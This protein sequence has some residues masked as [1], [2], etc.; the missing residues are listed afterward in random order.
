MKF[1]DQLN[2]TYI[3]LN[4]NR[5]KG[6]RL[7]IDQQ[8]S[9]HTLNKVFFNF[10]IIIQS[11]M[12]YFADFIFHYTS[13]DL[14]VHL[15]Q[16]SDMTLDNEF[17]EDYN[18]I[19]NLVKILTLIRTLRSEQ[20]LN[21]K[22]PIKELIICCTNEFQLSNLIEIL[23]IEGNIMN[24]SFDDIHK[25][26]STEMLPNNKTIGKQF[27]K[28]SKQIL[29]SLNSLN[30]IQYN[31]PID[32][33]GFILN[34]EHFILNK[35]CSKKE[36]YEY[37]LDDILLYIDITQDDETNVLYHSKIIVRET[38]KF[39]QELGLKPINPIYINYNT[40]NDYFKSVIHNRK[41][42]IDDII[43]YDFS[44]NEEESKNELLGR[45]NISIEDDF[46]EIEIFEM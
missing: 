17:N 36:G 41:E 34:E 37:I 11:S 30:D 7:L 38:Q 25:Y 45:K 46:I 31:F 43:K 20:K 33:N 2:N 21:N 9:I 10:S 18:T 23:Y 32:I 19:D 16:Y 40:D 3:K 39:R 6:N 15:K 24:I 22:K 29:N 35:S 26:T 5:I 12:P 27:K 8:M 42:Y 44:L 13:T 1:V 4:R 28:D 14:S